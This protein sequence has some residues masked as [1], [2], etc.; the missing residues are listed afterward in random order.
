MT[1]EERPENTSQEENT[2]LLGKLEEENRELKEK[3]LYLRAELENVKKL[4]VKEVEKARVE[5]AERILRRVI[6]IYENMRRAV[7][8]IE[9]GKNPFALAEGIKLILKDVEALLNSEGV[10][11]MEV[12]GK[13]FDPFTHEAIAFTEDPTIENDNTI[14]EEIDPGYTLGEKILKPP[15]VRVARKPKHPEEQL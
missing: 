8:D 5:T 4:M 6:T 1:Q 11:R 3:L 10:K 15:K 2:N 14:I 9:H 7:E 12:I 13:P